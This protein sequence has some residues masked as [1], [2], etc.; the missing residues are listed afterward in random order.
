MKSDNTLK[1]IYYDTQDP[2]SF[3]G[4]ARLSKASKTKKQ[5]V[6]RWL[7]LQDTYTLHKTA[8]KKF[9]RRR[10]IVHGINSQ[11][12]ADLIDVQNIKRD[13]DDHG[14]ILTCIDVF[15]KMGYAKALRNKSSTWIIP[16]FEEI[17]KEAG[18]PQKMQTDK[19]SEFLSRVVQKYFKEK[20]IEHFTSQNETIKCAVVERFNRTL[21]DRLFR[22]F[23]WSNSYRYIEALPN[24]VK[25]YNHSYHR[26]IK[27]KPIEVNSQNSHEVWESLYR[28]PRFSSL[29][30]FKPGDRVRI[31]K[32]KQTFTKGYLQAWS[33]ELFT[34]IQ[35]LQTT[36]K[37]YKIRDD[38]GEIII[39]SFYSQEL[40]KV[41]DKEDYRIE[42]IIDERRSKGKRKELFVKWLGYPDSF[43]SWIPQSYLKIYNGKSFHDR[44]RYK[45]SRRE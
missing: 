20:N 1:R 29:S 45:R 10:T 32:R 28:N 31:S 17:F 30:K 33:M 38:A 39:G 40:Q 25:A 19:G 36:P 4:V 14:Y 34:V 44:G 41:G 24:I 22:F 27:R 7:S 35:V 42:K 43:N 11:F 2:G 16:A 5:N 3:G 21:K 37:T 26:S 15:S 23:T 8:R 6:Q 18:I 13:N 9:P 12:Q